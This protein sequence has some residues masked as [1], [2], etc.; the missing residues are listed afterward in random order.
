MNKVLLLA[1]A[2]VVVSLLCCG[3]S[4]S[5]TVSIIDLVSS[6]E[7]YNGKTVTVEG[8]Y[9]RGW[10]WVLLAEDAALIGNKGVNE[11]QP[12]G[13]TIWFAGLIP[14]DVQKKLHKHSITET[15]SQYY[16]KVKVTGLFEY[17]ARYG[18]MNAYKYR[19]TA[20]EIEALDWTLP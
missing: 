15:E 13:E 18:H 14:I 6:P 9:I 3:C 12:V 17:G 16:G 11:I 1:I 2:L 7:Q 10:E 19:I 5:Q 4:T 20:T 8:I